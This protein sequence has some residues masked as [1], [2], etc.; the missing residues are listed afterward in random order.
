MKVEYVDYG[1][2]N[3]FEDSIEINKYLQNYPSLLQPIL[4]HEQSHSDETFTGKDLMLDIAC[5]DKI[6]TW[7]LLKFMCKHPKSFMQ[8]LPFY[9]Q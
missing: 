9:W 4:K 7:K 6:D 1:I 8:I 3:R 5:L 2:A